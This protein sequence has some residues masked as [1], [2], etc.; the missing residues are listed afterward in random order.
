MRATTADSSVVV[1][2]HLSEEIPDRNKLKNVRVPKRKK[3]N[4]YLEVV[5]KFSIGLK[6]TAGQGVQPEEYK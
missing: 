4:I 3:S 1:V 6:I 2:A 5:S